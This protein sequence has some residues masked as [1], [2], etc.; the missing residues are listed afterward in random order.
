MPRTPSFNPDARQVPGNVNIQ[1]LTRLDNVG[2]APTEEPDGVFAR[3]IYHVI[4]RDCGDVTRSESG[5]HVNDA[6]IR[7]AAL[8]R[9]RHLAWHLRALAEEIDAA[10]R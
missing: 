9:Q 1:P 6:R 7:E 3:A 4:C 8:Y 10:S 2:T 5:G